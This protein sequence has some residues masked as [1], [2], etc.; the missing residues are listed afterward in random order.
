MVTLNTLNTLV[1]DIMLIVRN[2]N[3]SASESINRLQVEQ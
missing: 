2:S 1:D 3:I